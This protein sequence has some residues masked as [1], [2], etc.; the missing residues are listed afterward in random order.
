MLEELHVVDFAII[1]DLTVRFTEGLN[2]LSGETGAGKSILVGAVG[3]LLGMK[4]DTESI[5]T[6]SDEAVVSGTVRIDGNREA[7]QWLEDHEIEPE[8]GAIIIRR[9]LKR[10]GRGS[11]FIQSSA[12]TRRDLSELTSYLFDMHGQ[13][14]HQSL[15][16]IDNHRKLLDRFG[17]HEERTKQLAHDFGRLSSLKK[18][19]ESMQK[20]ERERLRE[21]DIISYA[22]KEI[23]E[24]GLQEGEE[25]ELEKERRILSQHEQLFNQLETVHRRTAESRGGCVADLREALGA[26]E[27]IARIDEQLQPLQ[28]RLEEAFYEIE[29]IV[30][31]VRE[32]QNNMQFSAERLEQCEQRLMTIHSL[33]KKY[34]DTIGEVLD[35]YRKSKEKLE[36][37]GNWE[38]NKESL[39][40]EIHELEQKV[41]SQAHKLSELRKTVAQTLKARISEKL[42]LLGMEKAEF[43]IEIQQKKSPQ[44]K[45]ICGSYG[46]DTVE[47]TFSPNIGEPPKSLRAIA[48][49]GELSRVMLAI[50]SILAEKDTIQSLIFDEVDSGIGGQVAVAVGEHLHKL[51]RVKQILCITHL[52]AIA[53]RADNQLHVQKKEKEQRTITDVYTVEGDER[54]R[55]IARMLAGDTNGEASLT[56]AQELLKKYRGAEA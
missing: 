30:D 52:A 11:I 22:I 21:M 56:H 55:E 46:F 24:A 19:L 13:H 39:E 3:L 32:Y 53:V 54:V 23:E 1:D 25:E 33:E 35:Y 40:R 34:G 41:Y 48:S 17:E 31:T 44:G 37:M 12:V 4:G 10:S 26:M 16:S 5:R 36:N 14:E 27:E 43:H 28:T 20:S 29:D 45:P 49:G 50:K 47:F 42:K 2:I 38:E 15:L 8:E 9:V 51:S 7:L 18:Q 6:G